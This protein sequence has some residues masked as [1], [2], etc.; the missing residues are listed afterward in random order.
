[1]CDILGELLEIGEVTIVKN[2]HLKANKEEWLKERE[3]VGDKEFSEHTWNT[4]EKEN[5][6]Y[7]VRLKAD[8]HLFWIDSLWALASTLEVACKKAILNY[9]E[10]VNFFETGKGE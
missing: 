9:N 1:M 4:C 10:L 7:Y 8:T 2:Y 5:Q 6:S 3:L